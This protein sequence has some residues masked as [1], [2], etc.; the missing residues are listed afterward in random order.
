MKK[1]W[2]VTIARLGAVLLLFFFIG[3][4]F[5]PP[6]SQSY[7][8]P[9]LGASMG[10]VNVGI[11]I[12]FV[13]VLNNSEKF[14]AILFANI[15]MGLFSVFFHLVQQNSVVVM[16][17]ASI[18]LFASLVPLLFF[19]LNDYTR[20]QA[21]HPRTKPKKRA[22]FTLA[23]NF[24]F[25]L[26]VLGVG[27]GMLDGN[28]TESTAYLY[29]VYFGGGL[30]ACLLYYLLFAFL[31][32]SLQMSWN[33]TFAAFFLAVLI[34]SLSPNNAVALFLFSFLMG[35]ASS[36]GTICMFY[37]VGVIGKK[38]N[39]MNHLKLPLWFGVAGGIGFVLIGFTFNGLSNETLALIIPIVSAVMALIY[40]VAAP[41]LT[42]GYFKDDWVEDSEMSEIDAH[43]LSL[44]EKYGLSK[45]EAEVCRLLLEGYTMRQVG[46]AL[47]ISQATVNTHCTS[48]YRKANVNSKIQLL[49]LFAE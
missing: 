49:K 11:L 41:I 28:V 25:A 10:L 37:N 42:Q 3:M 44:F 21:L 15:L 17:A 29:L 14:Y 23:L 7:L 39:N 26:I 19:K 18:I 40:F 38:Y 5:I 9:F 47:D 34:N 32:S 33:S 20:K 6:S 12:P 30:F 35:V 46:S 27:K 4:L 48:L 24:A 13:F 8:A 22:Y 31:N 2:F 43:L 16:A 45:R 1:Q 36:L